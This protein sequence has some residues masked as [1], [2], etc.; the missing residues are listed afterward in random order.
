MEQVRVLKAILRLIGISHHI[1]Q[2]T[3]TWFLICVQN[4]A[5]AK[6][7]EGLVM[8]F[9]HHM[10]N[11]SPEKKCFQRVWRGNKRFE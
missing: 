8:M 7:T 1:K 2:E 3:A 6:H 5:C 11:I 10:R 4:K 9:S